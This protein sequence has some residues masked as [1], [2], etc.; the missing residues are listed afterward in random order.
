MSGSCMSKTCCQWPTT[1][2]DSGW[3]QDMNHVDGDQDDKMRCGVALRDLGPE[4]RQGEVC[5]R[6]SNIARVESKLVQSHTPPTHVCS[7]VCNTF[8]LPLHQAKSFGST[9]P[10][11]GAKVSQC[12]VAS[13]LVISIPIDMVH[14]S[15]CNLDS[16]DVVVH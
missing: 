12:N 15:W 14:R 5:L 9:L 8:D 6:Q 1:S 11:L 10:L 2:R 16:W 4:Q 3:R 13:H 7:I